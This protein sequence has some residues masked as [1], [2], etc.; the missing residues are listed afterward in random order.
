MTTKQIKARKAE[1]IARALLKGR[2]MVQLVEMYEATADNKPSIEDAM[3]RGWLLDEI[4]SQNPEGFDAWL[5]T[6]ECRDEEL[7]FYVM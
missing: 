4:K 3:L 6:P 2:T 7:R 1:N 5:D